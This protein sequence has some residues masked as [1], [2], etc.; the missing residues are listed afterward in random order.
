MTELWAREA[1]VLWPTYARPEVEFVRGSGV[2]LWDA[3]GREYLDFLG[4]IAVVAAGHAHPRVVEA[5][6]RQLATLGHTSN[7]YFTGPQV[8]LAE[9]L[10]D[11]FGGGAKV[12][13]SNS[14]A[15]ANEAAIKVARRWGRATRGE[16]ATGIVAAERLPAGR[17]GADRRSRGAAD[18]RRD[19]VGHGPHRP[20]VRPPARRHP[21]RRGDHGQGA[22]LRLPDRRHHRPR[23]GGRH[24]APRRPRHHLRRQPG[25]LRGRAG[26][27]RRGR[28]AAG[29]PRR[30]G[31][32][33][34]GRRAAGAA[35][36]GRRARRGARGRAVAGPGPGRGRRPRQ[37]G[38]ASRPRPRPGGQPGHRDRPA[39]GPT[40]GGDRGGGRRGAPPAGRG[41]RGGGRVS[42]KAA[43]QRALADLLRTRQ[44]SSQARVLEHLRQ[45]GFDATQ[46]TVSRDL[47]DLGAVK[48]RA[49][50]GRLVYALPEPDGGPA[51]RAEV[52][53]VLG[54]SL[55]AV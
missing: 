43:R 9:R 10:V 26:H 34:A 46:A 2:R 23:R 18:P 21:A 49:A 31:R 48:V 52:G 1:A 6:S 53:R 3:R 13:L 14:G 7:L 17:Q 12:F 39:A 30:Q 40:P 15:E 44:V 42:L 5:I 29:R 24:H 19:P 28:A 11:R 41:A 38:R 25:R 37:A 27:P 55:V 20:A 4:G 16:E 8:A 51:G 50:D 47:E 22:R 33:P 32:R 36:P 54:A 45:L 35:R